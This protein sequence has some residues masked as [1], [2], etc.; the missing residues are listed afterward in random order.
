MICQE[1]FKN[2]F[3]MDFLKRVTLTDHRFKEIENRKSVRIHIEFIAQLF[4]G[5][6]LVFDQQSKNESYEFTRCKREC[7]FMLMLGNLSIF[8]GIVFGIF[9]DVFSNAVGCLTKVI[10]KIG[11]S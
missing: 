3:D 9:R 1:P 8:S 2:D 7:S 11:I 4:A 6:Q 10:A 5:V